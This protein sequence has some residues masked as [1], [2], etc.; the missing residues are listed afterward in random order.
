MHFR[1]QWRRVDRGSGA[2]GLSRAERIDVEKRHLQET[3]KK[4]TFSILLLT[5]RLAAGLA[6]AAT[7]ENQH[8][9]LC[10]QQ[11]VLGRTGLLHF[12]L[13][14]PSLRRYWLHRPRQQ[15][16][17]GL[18]RLIIPYSDG[19]VDSISKCEVIS[20]SGESMPQG[21]KTCSRRESCPLESSSPR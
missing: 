7:N 11:L 20:S 10:Q 4:R 12:P 14:R 3:M 2:P 18:S 17:D 16:R 1:A 19:L 13:G 5:A 8:F 21:K 9:V 15:E 6:N